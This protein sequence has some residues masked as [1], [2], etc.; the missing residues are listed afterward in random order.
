MQKEADLENC[1]KEGMTN[2]V[3]REW[4]SGERFR[5]GENWRQFLG[6]LDDKRI[7]GAVDSLRAMLGVEHLKGKRFV[8]VGSG[9]GLFSLAARKLGATVHSFDYDPT[10]VWCTGE[11]RRRYFPEDASW[12]VEQGSALDAEYLKRLGTFDVAYSWGVLHHTGQMWR[13]LELVGQ[14]VKPGGR[15]FISIYNDQGR[16]SR[17]WKVVKRTFCRLPRLLK[18]LVLIPAGLVIW[19]PRCLLDALRL[20]PFE[21]WSKYRERRGMSPWR[22][23][24]DWVGGYPFEVA[25][26]EEIFDF[27]HKRAF[28]LRRLK[29]TDSFGTNEFVFERP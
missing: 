16:K 11:L 7:E 4:D 28:I 22:D 29:T 12:T 9:S 20:K 18:P 26:P 5:F 10:S 1:N 27:Y 23:V 19:G 13:A 14:L 25:K 15:L 3:S 2:T 21:T 17:Q 24:V 8:D 6:V